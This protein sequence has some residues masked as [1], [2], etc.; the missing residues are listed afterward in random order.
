L[1]STHKTMQNSFAAQPVHPVEVF[2]AR[3]GQELAGRIAG[4]LERCGLLK[5][6]TA[7]TKIAVKP[8]L[9]YPFFKPGVTTSPLVLRAVV[10]ALRQFTPHIVIVESDGCSSAWTA[11]AAFAGHEIPEI[12]KDFD[13]TCRGLT[14]LER[15]V[16][17]TTVAGREIEMELPRLLLDE[18]D[19]VLTVPVP[20]IHVMT[21]VSL[22]FKNQW[23]CI[24]DAKR[25]KHH[26][27]FPHKVLAVNKLIRSRVAVF[28]GTTFLNRTG[29]MFGDPV[30]MDVVVV[31]ETGDATLACCSVMQIDPATISHLRLA[32]AEGMMPG[33]VAAISIRGDAAH[34][35]RRFYLQR[36]PLDWVS[37][38][39]FHSAAATKLCY[40]SPAAKFLHDVLYA[41]KGRPKDFSPE[42]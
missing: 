23:G 28:D 29:P 7:D 4:S 41:I 37:V 35:S 18:T 14:G 6:V 1:A 11:E 24:P 12:C 19:F 22:G 17:T 9:T 25:L 34:V 21:G 13:I 31:G 36:K 20:K 10:G 33:D 39:F 5:N 26:A 38:A 27:E 32:I 40:D 30:P 3:H 8:N 42:W 2:S 16:A 15:R